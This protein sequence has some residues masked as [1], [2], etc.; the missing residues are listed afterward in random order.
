M[1]DVQLTDRSV[2][3]ASSHKRNYAITHRAF[4][5]ARV[6]KTMTSDCSLAAELVG[7]NSLRALLIRSASKFHPQTVL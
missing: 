2:K 1:N 4:T 3:N 6:L 7:Q 5:D